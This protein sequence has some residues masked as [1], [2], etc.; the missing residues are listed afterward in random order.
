MWPHNKIVITPRNPIVEWE[1]INL[2][3]FY[4]YVELTP[5]FLLPSFT[6]LTRTTS[7]SVTIP[8]SI[9]QISI[10]ID[11]QYQYQYRY[12]YRY[13]YQ[14]R[15]GFYWFLCD[16]FAN[17]YTHLH[18]ITFFSPNFFFPIP[19]CDFWIILAQKYNLK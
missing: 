5:Y 7:I 16:F 13:R 10:S 4:Y 19:I 8:I 9:I 3:T 6:L 17:F 2:T 18:E 1:V 12:W 15:I 11:N 14:Y